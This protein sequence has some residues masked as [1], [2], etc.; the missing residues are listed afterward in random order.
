[1]VDVRVGR[2]PTWVDAARLLG[3]GEWSLS[4]S[5]A[6]GRVAE[7]SLSPKQAADLDA[8]LRGLGLGLGPLE[9]QATPRLPR[10]LVRAA[11][12]DDARRRRETTTGFSKRGARLDE[13]GRFS[14]T[15]EPLALAIAEKAAG[16]AVIDATAGCGGNAIAFARRGSRVVA[17][18]RDRSRLELLGHNAGLY[19]VREAIDRRAGDARDLA[20][21]AEGAILFV[22]PPWGAAW[23]RRAMGLADLPLLAAL[24]ALA[25]RTRAEE[26][27]AKVPPS[28]LVGELPGADAEAYFGEAA[29]DRRRVK[30]VLVR[31]PINR[32]QG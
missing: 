23:D 31:L 1:M 27:W 14:L 25:P 32:A 30:L 10:A 8:R 16:R 6:G 21:E 11:R 29:G 26:L 22:D 20:L 17:I 2:L 3:E 18:E 12:S 9:V 24:V 7:A 15:P 5:D 13:E 28:F 19:G 4:A